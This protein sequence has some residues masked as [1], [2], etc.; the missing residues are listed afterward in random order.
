MYRIFEGEFLS[1]HNSRVGQRTGYWGSWF[2]VTTVLSRQPLPT[3][4]LLVSVSVR[5]HEGK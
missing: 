4:L 5:T 1:L 3:T 2:F